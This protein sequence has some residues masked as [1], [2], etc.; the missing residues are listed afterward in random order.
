MDARPEVSAIGTA[1][2]GPGD[3]VR[4]K[5]EIIEEWLD[6][7]E[8]PS[9]PLTAWEADFLISIRDQF[10]RSGRLSERQEELLE[11]VYVA[12]A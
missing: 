3:R 4:H 12:K 2:G 9:K 10:D 6:R 8:S 1:A 11:A 5:S 7:L